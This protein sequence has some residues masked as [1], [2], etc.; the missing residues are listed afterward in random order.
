[1]N[2]KEIK[3]IMRESPSGGTCWSSLAFCCS[4]K[5]K[6]KFR[7]RVMKQIG[8]TKKQFRNLKEDFDKKLF[9]LLKGGKHDRNKNRM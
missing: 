3:K 5:R 4:L 2:E 1:M 7:D 6:C 9:K 8:L